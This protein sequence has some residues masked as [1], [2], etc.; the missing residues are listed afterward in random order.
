MTDPGDADVTGD[1][2]TIGDT[3][4]PE[5]SADSDCPQTDLGACETSTCDLVTGTCA[6]GLAAEGAI[7]DDDNLCTGDGTCTADGVCSDG[8]WLMCKQDDNP[9]TTT[10]CAVE[11]GECETYNGEDGAAC[12]EEA[13]GTSCWEGA[14]VKTPVCGDGVVDAGETCDDSNAETEACAYGEMECTV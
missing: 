6:T 13:A 7:C 1:A 4:A 5:C 9:C 12:G 3:A 11:T 14:C 8:G 2:E 10:A